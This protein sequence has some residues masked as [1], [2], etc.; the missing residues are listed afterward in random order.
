MT[1]AQEL[2]VNVWKAKTAEEAENFIDQFL[3]SY[4]RLGGKYNTHSCASFLIEELVKLKNSPWT[5][6]QSAQPLLR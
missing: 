3:N 1:R 5:E 6:Q 2:Q 4:I